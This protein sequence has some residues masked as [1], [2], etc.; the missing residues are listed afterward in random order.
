VANTV[1]FLEARKPP[2]HCDLCGELVQHGKICTDCLGSNTPQVINRILVGK[3]R[4]LEVEFEDSAKDCYP[5]LS[6][7]KGDDIECHNFNCEKYFNR[8]TA[9]IRLNQ[10]KGLESEILS[11]L[12]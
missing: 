9:T 3:R 6:I 5:C 7:H 10:F 8:M 11:K 4:K 1:E 2:T 12:Q